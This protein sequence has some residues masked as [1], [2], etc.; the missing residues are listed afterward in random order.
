MRFRTS[1]YPTASSCV[2]PSTTRTDLAWLCALC[3]VPPPHKPPCLSRT[4]R[5]VTALRRCRS[6]VSRPAAAVASPSTAS[7]A[8]SRAALGRPRNAAA[9]Q[10]LQLG[11]EQNNP[12][13]IPSLQNNDHACAHQYELGHPPGALFA[14]AFLLLMCDIVFSYLYSSSSSSGLHLCA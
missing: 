5:C 9:G 4:R 8:T 10:C 14:W 13:A 1:G 6:V 7:A 3:I 11:S 12:N 2:T